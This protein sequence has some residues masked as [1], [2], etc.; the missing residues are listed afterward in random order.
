MDMK[1]F[2]CKENLRKQNLEVKIHK[3]EAKQAAPSHLGFSLAKFI[4]VI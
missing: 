3:S 4:G 2:G 1:I